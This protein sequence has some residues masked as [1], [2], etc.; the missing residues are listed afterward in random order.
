M[1]KTYILVDEYYENP[2]KQSVLIH[3]SNRVCN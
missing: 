1:I 2:E 3:R